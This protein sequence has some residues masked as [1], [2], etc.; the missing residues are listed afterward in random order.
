MT[1]TQSGPLQ[2]VKVLDLTA[3]VMGPFATQTLAALG[4]DVIKVEAPGGDN[5]RQVGPMRNAGMGHIFLH[6]NQG[7]RSIVL[8]L[9]TP[10][11]LQ[12]LLRLVEQA[13]VFITNIRPPALARLG[14]G[15][16]AVRQRNPRIVYV[17]CSGFGQDGPYADKPAY[18]DLIQGAVGLPSLMHR[19]GIDPPCY[20]PVLVADR[21]AGLHAVYAV[22]AALFARERTGLGQ[23]VEVPMFETMAQLVLADHL[24]GASF[25]PPVA[26]PGYARLLIRHR[27]PFRTLD[28]YLCVVLYNDKHWTAF[29]NA[30]GDGSRMVDDP[31]FTTLG[32]RTRHIDAVYSHIA[33]VLR[34]RSTA[35]WRALLNGA[36]IPNMPMNSLDDLLEDPQ[37]LATGLVRHTEHPTEGAIRTLAQPTRWPQMP[38]RDASA[39]PG[40]GEHTS[41][42]LR[43]AGYDDA[44]IAALCSSG[45]AFQAAVGSRPD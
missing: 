42:V 39:A 2:G 44:G 12:A 4:A 18:D 35:E 16:D 33:D 38:L 13:D 37:L 5:M 19:H 27:R 26:G 28:G 3:V 6:A 41:Q 24:A 25:E 30:I 1:T 23:K 11:G 8:D 14:L 31:R 9:K 17:G 22:T 15:Y 21:V 7:K 10:G 45:A 32:A 40:L 43:E 20:A 34:T 36:D 29:F